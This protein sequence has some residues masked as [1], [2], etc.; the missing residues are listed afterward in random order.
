MKGKFISF[1][2]LDGSGKT[3]QCELLKK[4]IE[5]V[6][7]IKTTIVPGY[8]PS[9][10]VANLKNVAER[11]DEHYQELFSC[12]NLSLSLLCDLWENTHNIII[13][14][15][16][17][18]EVVLTERY[19]ESSLIYAPILGANKNLIEGVVSLFPKPDMFIYL[20][21]SPDISHKRVINRAKETN[22]PVMPKERLEIMELANKSYLEFAK[23]CDC[24][25]INTENL[26]FD[27]VHQKVKQH[28][29]TL[30]NDMVLMGN[31]A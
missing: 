29:N 22:I 1:C 9:R 7:H 30:L 13:P 25:V 31:D 16:N 17:R 15:L 21:I 2:G 27:D 19:W 4:Y 28:V 3:S 23:K 11:L 18:G 6:F 5:D 20:E 8:K 26:S 24:K 12:D 10:H 14:A